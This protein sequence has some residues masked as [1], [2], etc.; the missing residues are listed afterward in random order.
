MND[1]D[2]QVPVEG[3]NKYLELVRRREQLL[4]E[5]PSLRETQNKIERTLEEVGDNPYFRCRVLNII[6]MQSYHNLMTANE[7]I[8]DDVTELQM[9]IK[10]FEETCLK[11]KELG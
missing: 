10:G 9:A 1:K 5:N 11:L 3:M 6:L 8:Y 4:A 2:L 7:A